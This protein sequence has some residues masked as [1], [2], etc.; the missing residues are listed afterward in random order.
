MLSTLFTKTQKCYRSF[1]NLF[2]LLW[3]NSRQASTGGCERTLYL[4]LICIKIKKRPNKIV[5]RLNQLM[6]LSNGIL[7]CPGSLHHLVA[8]SP[9]ELL[10]ARCWGLPSISQHRLPGKIFYRQNT[11]GKLQPLLLVMDPIVSEASNILK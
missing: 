4:S 7:T 9:S 3:Y 2:F 1:K 11:Q 8:A 6:M 10:Q 5:I